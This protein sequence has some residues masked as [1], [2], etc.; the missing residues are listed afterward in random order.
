MK[1]TADGRTA[2]SLAGK[3]SAGGAFPGPIGGHRDC[4]IHMLKINRHPIDC[5]QPFRKKNRVV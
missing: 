4:D 5:F 2:P 1:K 3:N